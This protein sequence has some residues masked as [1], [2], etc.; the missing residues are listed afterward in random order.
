MFKTTFTGKTVT[1]SPVVSLPYH[2]Q[3]AATKLDPVETRQDVATLF[4][5]CAI[6]LSV[7]GLRFLSVV[8]RGVAGAVERLLIT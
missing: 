3:R 4:S 8:A 5:P 6:S 1:E 7:S 2:F